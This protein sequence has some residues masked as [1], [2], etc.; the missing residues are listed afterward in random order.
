MDL[1]FDLYYSEGNDI[2]AECIDDGLEKIRSRA[3]RRHKDYSKAIRKRNISDAIYRPLGDKHY[4]NNLHQYSKNKIHCS[5]RTT[6]I[7]RTK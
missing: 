3:Y 4:F 2:Y 5:C 6:S 1:A 7:Y